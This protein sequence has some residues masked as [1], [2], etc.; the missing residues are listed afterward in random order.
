[1]EALEYTWR[2]HMH[3]L[4]SPVAETR[5][6]ALEELTE[7]GATQ[8]VP[9]IVALLS[10]PE[11]GVR[12]RAAAALGRLGR[13][14]AKSKIAAL[15]GDAD[16]RVRWRAA[17]ALAWMGEAGAIVGLIGDP[18]PDVRRLVLYTLGTELGDAAL[19]L[20]TDDDAGVRRAAVQV[21]GTS[22]GADLLSEC[23][24]DL[25]PHVRIE[26]ARMLA[27]LG[28]Y[29]DKVQALLL[30]EHAGVRRAAI[31]ALARMQRREPVGRMFHDRDPKVRATAVR[32]MASMN[33][34]EGTAE[35]GRRLLDPELRPAVLDALGVL[36]AIDWA[37]SVALFLVDTDPDVRG[38]AV[39][40]LGLMGSTAHL[41]S[42]RP[43]LEDVDTRVREHAAEALIDLSTEPQPA[44]PIVLPDGA[45]ERALIEQVRDPVPGTAGAAGLLDALAARHEPAAWSKLEAPQRLD[46]PIA[47]VA[48]VA[49]LL[50]SLGLALEGVA[51]CTFVGCFAADTVV[52]PRR[53]LDRLRRAVVPAGDVIRMMTVNDALDCWDRRLE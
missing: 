38:R 26:A 15:L 49:K 35:I 5:A 24:S 11:P 30:D 3:Y 9:E 19:P 47:S 50:Q 6:R 18:S 48:D 1:M 17:D 34:R 46:F 43:L 16:D 23:L 45:D 8:A 32:A 40:A 4:R 20:L 33:A 53:V 25:D 51:D 37:N 52:A 36:G 28:R 31:E 13:S 42:I 27:T 10:D 7:L 29:A 21:L 14:D 39:R 41:D 44:P 22:L 12:G 2:D